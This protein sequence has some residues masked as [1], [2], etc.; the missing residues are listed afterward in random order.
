MFAKTREASG[1]G[2]GDEQGGDGESLFYKFAINHWGCRWFW[3][4]IVGAP[5]AVKNLGNEAGELYGDLKSTKLDQEVLDRRLRD[6]KTPED[7]QRVYGD[8]WREAMEQTAKLAKIGVQ[9]E[10]IIGGMVVRPGTVM[11]SGCEQAATQL[12]KMVGGKAV[13]I[14]PARGRYL[15][16]FA[17]KQPKWETHTVVVSNGRVY[18]AYTGVGGMLI[19]E[20]KKLWEW[21]GDIN[22][23]F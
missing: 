13:T 17:G 8:Q 22:F 2:G 19:D 12:Q 4:L 1:E 21:A 14:T 5:G 7:Y 9:A 3:R 11:S 16:G 18:D 23:G 15:G 6:L 20:Y 10:L